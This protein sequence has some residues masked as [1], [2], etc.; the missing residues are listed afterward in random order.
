MSSAD[1]SCTPLSA[2]KVPRCR[3]LELPTE[4]RLEIYE[5]AT[6]TSDV[7]NRIEITARG[8]QRSPLVLTCKAIH[9]DANNVFLRQNWFHHEMFGFN[10]TTLVKFEDFCET[11]LTFF[12]QQSMEL[13]VT[14]NLSLV[15]LEDECLWHNLMAYL[16]SFHATKVTYALEQP[17]QIDGE[18]CDLE[19]LMMRHII[20][21][22][23]M[24]VDLSEE[25][26]PWGKFLVIFDGMRPSLI[27]LDDK[28]A[29]NL[30][31]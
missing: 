12:Q 3:L 7:D 11:H 15:V 27:A 18:H 22:M 5:F 8:F 2:N 19:T 10:S 9:D 25:E 4:L 28:W 31:E 30:R 1:A 29:R 16:Q 6:V 17:A 13:A 26:E 21:T 14:T 24:I 23:F 20:G